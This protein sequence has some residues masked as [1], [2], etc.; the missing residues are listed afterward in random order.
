MRLL[1]RYELMEL[2]GD[3]FA[4]DRGPINELLFE[5]SFRELPIEQKQYPHSKE[6]YR[7]LFTDS[8]NRKLLFIYDDESKQINISWRDIDKHN[9][10]PEGKKWSLFEVH[11]KDI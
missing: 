2:I 4:I 6:I 8:W 1:Q 5:L 3:N 9:S 10:N 11:G 7:E